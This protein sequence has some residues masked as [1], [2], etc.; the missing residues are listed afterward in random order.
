MTTKEIRQLAQM[1][2]EGCHHCDE[3]DKQFWVNGFIR[4]YLNA[5][6]GNIDKQN[7]ARHDKIADIL[8]NNVDPKCKYCGGEDRGQ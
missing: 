4:G 8:I 5:Q 7:E 1:Q 3:V 6:V 2:W